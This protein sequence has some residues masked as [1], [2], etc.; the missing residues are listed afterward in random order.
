MRR[1]SG[2]Q[3]LDKQDIEGDARIATV[4]YSLKKYGLHG[5]Y[6]LKE[7]TGL[8]EGVVRWTLANLRSLGL[9]RVVR[10][11]AAI[12]KLG[13]QC[14]SDLLG[15]YGF[16]RVEEVP[17]EEVFGGGYRGL[18]GYTGRAVGNL[19]AV[20][21]AMVRAGCHAALIVRR[22]SEVLRLPPLDIDVGA[23][24]PRLG[25]ALRGFLSD[26]TAWIM[27]AVAEKIYPGFLGLFAASL[28]EP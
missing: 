10:A 4:L 5:R 27:L 3:C 21:D 26:H 28:V 24:Y 18:A 16:E 11:G 8:G 25:R 22:E 14:Y 19:I 1:L 7:L 9:V 23:S 15:A 6:F 17:V 13:E 20:R 12:T 2:S